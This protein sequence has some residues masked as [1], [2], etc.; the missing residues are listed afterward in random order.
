MQSREA[1]L[2]RLISSVQT[3]GARWYTPPTMLP[4]RGALLQACVDRVGARQHAVVAGSPDDEGNSV[5]VVRALARRLP[6]YWLVGDDPVSLSWVLAGADGAERVRCLRRDSV[7]A[8]W[9]YVSARYVFFTHGLYGSPKPPRNKTFVNLWHGDGP[10]RRKGFATVRSTY[11]VSGTQLWGRQRVRNFGIPEKNVLITG[12]PRID[13]F[14]RPADDATLRELGI[15]PEKPFVLWLPTYRRTEYQGKRI[16]R[17]RNWSDA[18]ELSTSWQVRARLMQVAEDARDMGVTLAVKPHPL[19]GDTFTGT[20]LHVITNVDLRSAH[21]CLYQVLARAHG[22]LT[23]YSS[24]W[25]DFLSVDRP[26]GFYCPDLDEY[27]SGRGLNVDN[28]PELLPGPLLDTPQEFRTF[29]DTCI[30][31]PEWS[32]AQRKASIARIGAETQP[33][34]TERLLDAVGVPL[35]RSSSQPKPA[36]RSSVALNQQAP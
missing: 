13:Q 36:H 6:V 19:D 35:P 18:D 31:E 27:V 20:G 23:D 14:A 28:Y 7:A 3:A 29:L 34:A 26:I 21:V 25:T 24:V 32:K 9:A 17:L 2:G 30:N 16:G 5:E 8:F 10:K 33:G 11:V 4:A 1:L 15:D 12:N 22:L